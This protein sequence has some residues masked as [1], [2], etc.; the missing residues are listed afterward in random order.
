MSRPLPSRLSFCVS[1]C[2]TASRAVR[3]RRHKANF[4]IHCMQFGTRELLEPTRANSSQLSL[5]N[6]LACGAAQACSPKRWMTNP[7]ELF[8]SETHS[9]IHALISCVTRRLFCFSAYLIC[10]NMY[11]LM[12]CGYILNAHASAVYSSSA[13]LPGD[14]GRRLLALI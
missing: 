1:L 14:S 13:F 7:G 9:G 12:L 8:S 2:A 5:V 10:T 4:V 6:A 11:V 3:S